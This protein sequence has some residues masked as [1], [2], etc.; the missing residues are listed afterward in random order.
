MCSTWMVQELMAHPHLALLV[1]PWQWQPLI[2]DVVQRR[3]Q[4]CEM[5]VLQEQL[6]VYQW[7]ID[8]VAGGTD[9]SARCIVAL[10][11]AEESGR[12]V[13]TPVQFAKWLQ[14]F[15]FRCLR[16]QPHA[17]HFLVF[18][19]AAYGATKRSLAQLGASVRSELSS[20]RLLIHSLSCS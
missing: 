14:Q 13:F 7:P 12:D 17:P 18:C 19:L 5:V 9:A 6:T 1:G 11:A 10:S 20:V 4:G 15:W 8:P 16:S 3:P 2:C